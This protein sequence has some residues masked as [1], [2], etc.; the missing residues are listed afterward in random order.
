MQITVNVNGQKVRVIPVH[1]DPLLAK[2]RQAQAEQVLASLSADDMPTIIL[3][4]FNATSRGA[5]CWSGKNASDDTLDRFTRAGFS[6]RFN[7]AD[8]PEQFTFPSDKPYQTID[9]I[10]TSK[11]FDFAHYETGDL[12]LSDHRPVTARLEWRNKETVTASSLNTHQPRK[13]NQP[14]KQWNEPSLSDI[15]IS[16][17]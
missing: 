7:G 10:L 8:T 16:T 17:R 9:Y 13:A 6:G 3:G 15:F 1:L 4:D 5:S 14:K 11:E 2:S 12:R